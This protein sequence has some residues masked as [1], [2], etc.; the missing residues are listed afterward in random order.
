MTPKTLDQKVVNIIL[1][2]I[3]S[4]YD[5]SFM[6]K[7]MSNWAQG[8]G[9]EKASSFYASESAD[10][11]THSDKLQKYLVDWNVIVEIPEI[12]A[13]RVEYGNLVQTIEEAYKAEYSLYEKYEDMAKKMFSLDLC[14]FALLQEMLAIQLKA[15]TEYSDKLNMLEGVDASKTNLLLLEKKLF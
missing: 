13:P 10:E 11:L 14:T 12:P 1:D 8:V 9:F 7:G 6:Y 4:E 3:A 5:A 15:V 2:L